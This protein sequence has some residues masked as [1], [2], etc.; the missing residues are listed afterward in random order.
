MP[1]YKKNFLSSVVF[2]LDFDEAKIGQL[3]SFAKKIK[4]NFPLLEQKE[5]QESMM[6][7]DTKTGNFQ[8]SNNKKVFWQITDA[9]KSKTIEIDNNFIAITY[10]K[11]K[12][13]KVLIKDVDEVFNAFLLD[14]DV[15][16]IRRTGLRYINE[17]GFPKEGR[18]LDWKKYITTELISQVNFITK[19]KLKTSRA[20]AQTVFRDEDVYITF[21]YG[22]VNFPFIRR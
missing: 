9:D 15:K 6:M 12:D 17:I 18:P 4:K 10:K 3:E 20:L 21:N 11:Y 13:S 19:T 8:H 2:R 22:L 14:F 16:T 1:V 7:L 5:R